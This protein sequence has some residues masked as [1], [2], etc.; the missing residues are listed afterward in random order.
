[1]KTALVAAGG[2]AMYY[3]YR[4]MKGNG[5]AS[6]SSEHPP[7]GNFDHEQPAPMLYKE[8]L[9]AINR[10]DY[11]TALNF[12]KTEAEN[13]SALAQL[14][15][16]EAYFS[17]IG[18]DKNVVEGVRYLSSAAHQGHTGAL[19]RLG[20]LYDTG[21]LA[22]DGVPEDIPR[23]NYYFQ[24]AYERGSPQAAFLLSWSYKEGEHVGKDISKTMELLQFTIDNLP[25]GDKVRARAAIILDTV[26]EEET[27]SA[28]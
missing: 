11:E 4:S 23:A 7:I 24:A 3:G 17:G 19:V 21:D 20:Q 1:M 16:S 10:G 25:E 26:K 12:L 14:K 15:L 5:A 9:T 2:A 8:A 18:T 22:S 6:Q 27:K 28:Q 13:G